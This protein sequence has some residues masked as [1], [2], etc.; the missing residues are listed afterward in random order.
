[1]CTRDMQ[2]EHG[3]QSPVEHQP[4]KLCSN[5]CPKRA[6]VWSDSDLI[7]VG[8][9]SWC[10]SLP[11]INDAVGGAVPSQTLI[12]TAPLLLPQP[13]DVGEELMATTFK[14]PFWP[15][16]IVIWM[17]RG[18][19][20]Q[21]ERVGFQTA[22]LRAPIWAGRGVVFIDSM[23]SDAI[24]LL[25]VRVPRAPRNFILKISKQLTKILIV[26][27]DKDNTDSKIDFFCLWFICIP[28]SFSEATGRT[29]YTLIIWATDKCCR[30]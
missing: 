24:Q 6:T 23:S 21:G 20:G 1:M 10:F 12:A 19:R 27:I 8:I 14:I 15:Q 22:S 3:R 16:R 25:A 13:S 26:T 29:F 7:Q 28:F 30:V 5:V 4:E 9:T 18:T 2:K 17:I 11:T